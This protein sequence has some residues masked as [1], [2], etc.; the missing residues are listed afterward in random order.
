M[1]RS[2]LVPNKEMGGFSDLVVLIPAPLILFIELKA[3]NGKQSPAQKAFQERVERMN[4][5]YYI[6]K[7]RND[8]CEI[9]NSN[10]VQTK[11][12]TK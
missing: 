4:H 6:S 3:E 1:G 9:L 7:G 5:K 2:V 12:F 11:W 8:L 10:G